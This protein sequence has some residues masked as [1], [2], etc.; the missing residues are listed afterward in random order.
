MI[1]FNRHLATSWAF[2]VQVGKAFTHPEKV[3]TNTSKYRGLFLAHRLH[4]SH[5]GEF[6]DIKMLGQGGL[7]SYLY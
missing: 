6:G 1:F 3:Q 7:K 2:S 4:L 5:T